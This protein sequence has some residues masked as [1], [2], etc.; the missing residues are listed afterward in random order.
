MQS[1]PAGA[2][3]GPRRRDYLWEAALPDLLSGRRRLYEEGAEV[4]WPQVQSNRKVAI[5]HDG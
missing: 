4:S 3:G 1:P 2:G 5:C